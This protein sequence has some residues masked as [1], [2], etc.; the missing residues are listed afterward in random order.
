[1]ITQEKKEPTSFEEYTN[2]NQTDGQ[3]GERNLKENT[4]GMKIKHESKVANDSILPESTMMSYEDC[5]DTMPN[6]TLIS[7]EEKPLCKDEEGVVSTEINEEEDDSYASSD[8][9]PESSCESL[10]AYESP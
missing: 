2:E 9:Y 5:S 3:S 8:F 10:S 4:G 7:P 6:E 1:M